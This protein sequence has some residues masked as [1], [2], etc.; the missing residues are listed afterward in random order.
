MYV[1]S[2]VG[3]EVSLCVKTNLVL[4]AIS[5]MK[6]GIVFFRNSWGRGNQGDHIDLWDGSRVRKG[7]L[8]Y[9]ERSQEVWFW[10]IS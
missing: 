6:T 4:C 9:F 3:M 10:P 1:W 5:K 7:G 2:P 8:D